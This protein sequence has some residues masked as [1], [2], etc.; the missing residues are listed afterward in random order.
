[1]KNKFHHWDIMNG[2]LE[3]QSGCQETGSAVE[4][5][6]KLGGVIKLGNFQVEIGLG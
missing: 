6:L 5:D 2:L 4:D 1:M 3:L